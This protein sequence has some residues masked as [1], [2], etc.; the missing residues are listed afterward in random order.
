MT[1]A[2]YHHVRPLDDGRWAVVHAIAGAAGHFAV[3][4][5]CMTMHAAE[6]EAAW[7]NAE[8][9]MAPAAS[10]EAAQA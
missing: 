6:R 8:R 4:L 3:D 5:E 10:D 2:G 9:D 1:G 7:L